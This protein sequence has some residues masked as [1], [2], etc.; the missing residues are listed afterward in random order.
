MRIFLG[1]LFLISAAASTLCLAGSPP[2]G[3]YITALAIDPSQPDTLF[4]ASNGAGVYRRDGLQGPWLKITPDTQLK[5][6]YTLVLHVG[7]P[8]LILTG[9]EKTGLWASEDGGG[10]WTRFGAEADW[11]VLDIATHPEIPRAVY[12]LTPEG[13]YYNRNYQNHWGWNRVFDYPQ[14]LEV[15]R[16]P[17]WPKSGWKFTRFQKITVHPEEPDTLFLGARW[18]GGYFQSSNAGKTWE[19]RGLNGIFRRGDELRVDPFQPGLWYSFTHHQGLF[20]SYNRG[21]SWVAAGKGLEPQVRTPHYAV[22]L[23]GGVAF[24]ETAPGLILSGSDYSTWIS[25]DHG[26]HWEEVGRTLTCEFVR[27]TAIHPENPDILF[28]GSNVGVFQ[29]LDRGKTWKV[30]NTGFPAKTVLKTLEVEMDGRSFRYALVK[31]TPSVYRRSL[32]KDA[33]YHPLGWLVY[34]RGIDLTWNE[35]TQTLLLTTM[36]GDLKSTDGG[37]R[38]S[39]PAVKLA[40]RELKNPDI[41]ISPIEGGPN[42]AIT[43]AAVPDAEP[44]LDFYKRPPFISIQLVSSGYPEDG[45]TPWWS[46][47]WERKLVGSLEVPKPLQQQ[48]ADVYVEVRDFHHGTRVGRAPYQGPEQTTVVRVEPLGSIPQK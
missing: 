39:V 20:K 7:N 6:W 38:W 29:S 21:E 3:A 33:Q 35:K 27:A 48:V 40:E 10:Y 30:A 37:F 45:S 41:F 23:L 32:E 14:W 28:A 46:T 24:S 17:D 8:G 44:L 11:T 18:E 26:E 1:F 42:L 43:N 9:G 19:H 36:E 13:V 12:V 2:A 34:D 47:N 15:N 5:K 16:K 4:A 22:Y 25:E 31:G